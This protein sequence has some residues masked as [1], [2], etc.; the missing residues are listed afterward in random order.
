MIQNGLTCLQK[1]SLIHTFIQVHSLLFSGIQG[2]V[3]SIPDSFCAGMKTI[4][5]EKGFLFTRKNS[6]FSAI[7]VTEQGAALR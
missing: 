4:I 7:S 3:H 1:C 2:Y 5:Y 6:D